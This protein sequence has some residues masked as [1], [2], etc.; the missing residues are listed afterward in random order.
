MILCLVTNICK[1]L[2]RVKLV[3]C[4]TWLNVRFDLLFVF[5]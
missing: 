5:K 4:V 2:S 1:L 3:M